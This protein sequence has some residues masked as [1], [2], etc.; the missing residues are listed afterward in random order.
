M[1]KEEYLHQVL[2][3]IHYIFDHNKIEEELNQHFED[4]IQDLMED[5]LS[6][7]EAEQQ[8]VK[9]MGDPVE[10]GKLLNQEHNPLLGYLCM[11]STVIL[12]PLGIFVSII[13]VIFLT[14]FITQ[15]T[16]TTIDTN[17]EAISL[18]IDVDLST[19]K[20]KIDNLYLLENGECT[21]TYRSWTKF[22]YSR[23]G[24]S[25]DLFY[26]EDYNGNVIPCGSFSS[27]TV[28]GSYG[29]R[30][31]S[32]PQD[33]SYIYVITFDGQKIELNLEEYYYEEN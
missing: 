4:S 11:I 14:T 20:V 16:P 18:D 5:G 27:Q 28:F 30:N 9:H 1:T 7:E 6:R 32:Y 17:A 25:S 2:K 19:H 13:A 24:R 3:Q 29:S 8:A 31:F 22:H 26:L 21:L 23:A 15:L 33:S 10:A 12:V